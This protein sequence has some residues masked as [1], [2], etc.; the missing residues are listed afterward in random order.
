MSKEVEPVLIRLSE[1]IDLRYNT[2]KYQ[3]DISCFIK[4]IYRYLK[5]YARQVSNQ[6][7]S[8][9]LF[10]DLNPEN[11]MLDQ[12]Q[13]MPF[14]HYEPIIN[15]AIGLRQKPFSLECRVAFAPTPKGFD[16]FKSPTEYQNDVDLMINDPLYGCELLYNN[17]ESLDILRKRAIN[18]E[19]K[20]L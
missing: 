14:L 4:E 7:K 1:F 18:E 2:E 5:E 16:Y 10:L 9:T 15:E 8:R 17:Q 20:Q 6:Y 19:R 3:A 11:I 13:L 12:L